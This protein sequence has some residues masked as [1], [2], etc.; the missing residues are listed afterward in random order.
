MDGASKEFWE[1]C[2]EGS[3]VTT[4]HGHIGSTGQS[5]TKAFS[6][7]SIADTE[8]RKLVHEKRRRGY[9]EVQ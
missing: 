9:A 5:M 2:V 1:I 7:P 4:R 8:A 3:R 6:G